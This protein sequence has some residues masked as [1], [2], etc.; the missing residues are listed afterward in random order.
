MV[1]DLLSGEPGFYHTVVYMILTAV[2]SVLTFKVGQYFPAI[3][4]KKEVNKIVIERQQCVPC[5]RQRQ[6]SFLRRKTKKKPKLDGFSADV[7]AVLPCIRKRRSVFPKNFVNQDV[8][9]NVMQSLLDAAVWAPYHGR[10][11]A[12]APPARF[13]VLGKKAM[14]DMQRLTLQFYDKNWQTTGWGSGTVGTQEEYDQWREMTEGEIT[15]RWGPVSY[16][17]AIVMQRQT[18]PKRFPEWEEAAATACAVQNMH[19]QA[20]SFPGLACYWS[21]WHDAARD[22]DEM[23]EFLKMGYEDKCLGFFIVASYNADLK[24]R[25]VRRREELN[26]DWRD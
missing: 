2:L 8:C 13:V 24:D 19:I 14:V 16:M 3:L 26:V 5:K 22:S 15:G 7:K 12:K 10:S 21:S 18:G 17:V 4:D 11:A 23:R 1:L 9:A 6:D 20:T 25:R